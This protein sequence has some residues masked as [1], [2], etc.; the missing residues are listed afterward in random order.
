MVQKEAGLAEHGTAQP[1][2]CC[3]GRGSQKAVKCAVYTCLRFT[4]CYSAIALQERG[5][6]FFESMLQKKE[7]KIPLF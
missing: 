4:E 7:Y 3:C 2:G 1:G 6:I 5:Y